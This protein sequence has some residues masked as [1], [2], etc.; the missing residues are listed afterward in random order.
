VIYK[1]VLYPNIGLIILGG[2]F[3]P[4]IL[5]TWDSIYSLI[6]TLAT[7]KAEDLRNKVI[8]TFQIEKFRPSKLDGDLMLEKS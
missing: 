4:S 3:G 8:F 1:Y 6:T 5:I 2:G 7:L